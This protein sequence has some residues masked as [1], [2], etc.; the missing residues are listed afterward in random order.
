MML[1]LQNIN[2]HIGK[3]VDNLLGLYFETLG[4]VISVMDYKIKNHDV[5]QELTQSWKQKD[6]QI[7]SL[8][9]EIQ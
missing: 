8:N 2:I 3:I 1:A 5:I 7:S 9:A 4:S 6:K